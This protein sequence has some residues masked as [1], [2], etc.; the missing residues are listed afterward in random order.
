M[1]LMRHIAEVV[2]KEGMLSLEFRISAVR[3]SLS[4]CFWEGKNFVMIALTHCSRDIPVVKGNVSMAAQ[5]LSV[6][7]TGPT[8]LFCGGAD[9]DFIE[10]LDRDPPRKFVVQYPFTLSPIQVEKLMHEP[11]FSVMWK[12]VVFSML[13]TLL[14]RLPGMLGEPWVQ[15]TWFLEKVRIIATRIKNN[16]LITFG[17]SGICLFKVLED[18]SLDLH[19]AFLVVQEMLSHRAQIVSYLSETGQRQE[20]QNEQ[21]RVILI[22]LLISRCLYGLI[23]ALIML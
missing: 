15:W 4:L 1:E 14:A 19:S 3:R 11:S 10:T 13:R 8:I 22:I 17:L 16:V 7:A 2:G 23:F 5:L 6:V 9:S 18:A 21:G 12:K 20:L